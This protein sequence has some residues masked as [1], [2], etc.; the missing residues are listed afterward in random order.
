[1]ADQPRRRAPGLGIIVA[2][3]LLILPIAGVAWWLNRPKGGGAASDP[4]L[5]DLDVVCLGRVDGLTPVASLEPAIPGRV[6]EVFVSEGQTVKSGERL[7]RLDDG[8]A[9]AQGR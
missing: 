1:M 3:A 4:G 9:P 6:A 7:L 8:A 5:A 2:T